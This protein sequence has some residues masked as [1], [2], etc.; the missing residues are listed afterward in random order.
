[1]QVNPV[2][3]YELHQQLL[4][5]LEDGDKVAFILDRKSLDLLIDAVLSYDDRLRDAKLQ[6]ELLDGMKQLR[7]QVFED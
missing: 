7:Q 6:V 2:S 1:M 5:A 4:I 3:K